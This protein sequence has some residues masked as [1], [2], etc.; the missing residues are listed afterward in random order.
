MLHRAGASST[1]GSR[2]LSQSASH[3]D[4][5]GWVD[6]EHVQ[7]LAHVHRTTCMDWQAAGGQA[8]QAL[9]ATVEDIPKTKGL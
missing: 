3:L 9:L 4:A 8:A 5:V 1:D 6:D 2:T 7:P